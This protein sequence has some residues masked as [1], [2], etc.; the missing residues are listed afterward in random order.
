MAEAQTRGGERKP[1]SRCL[2]EAVGHLVQAVKTPVPD[3]RRVVDRHSES[4]ERD[5]L[6]FRRTVID[7]VEPAPAAPARESESRS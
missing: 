2:G 6:V 5:G 7:E 3:R 1:I 4:R